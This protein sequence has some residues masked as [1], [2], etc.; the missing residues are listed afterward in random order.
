M[1]SCY[2]KPLSTRSADGLK[3]ATL[4]LNKPA[5]LLE[6]TFPLI[7]PR[8]L[9]LLPEHVQESGQDMPCLTQTLLRNKAIKLSTH[10]Q[11]A[12][13]AG[14]GCCTP[15]LLPQPVWC[16]GGCQSARAPC[17]GPGTRRPRSRARRLLWMTPAGQHG[18][19]SALLSAI[20]GQLT[21]GWQQRRAMI[22]QHTCCRRCVGSL[23]AAGTSHSTLRWNSSLLSGCCTR[24]EVAQLLT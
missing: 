13:P 22:T 20:Q 15:G 4:C 10:L 8:C 1:L 17:P 5:V 9:V 23:A 3:G 16:P 12:P 14:W 18:T 2:H 19:H 6:C 21:H 7:R 24:P 11:L